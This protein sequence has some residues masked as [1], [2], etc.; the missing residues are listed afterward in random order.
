MV[1]LEAM[2]GELET[3][4]E[5]RRA[6]RQEVVMAALRL[7]GGNVK[8]AAAACRVS[9]MTVYRVIRQGSNAE[10][11]DALQEASNAVQWGQRKEQREQRR[12]ERAEAERRELEAAKAHRETIRTSLAELLALNR[13]AQ[14][15]TAPRKPSMLMVAGRWVPDNR[16]FAHRRASA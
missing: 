10:E 2:L 7:H 14:S 5:A 8:Q 15:S 1:D 9:V 4:R 16:R 6:R 11:L 12:M 13:K 3:L